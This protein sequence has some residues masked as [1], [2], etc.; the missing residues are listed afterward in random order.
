[1]GVNDGK[2]G[3]WFVC[4]FVIVCLFGLFRGGLVDLSTS[5]FLSV[6]LPSS[7]PLFF[8]VFFF[9]VSGSTSHLPACTIYLLPR[10]IH[11]GVDGDGKGGTRI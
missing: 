7:F 2:G 6:C 4:F 1:M 3:W 5:V 8:S 11:F 10:C 9:L